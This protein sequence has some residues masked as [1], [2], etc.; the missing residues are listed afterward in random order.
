MVRRVA[1]YPSYSPTSDA[2]LAAGQVA[3]LRGDFF[4]PAVHLASRV[5]GAAPSS[6]VWATD[7]V[8]I[9]AQG[10][11]NFMFVPVGRHSLAGFSEPVALH[12]LERTITG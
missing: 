12:R 11:G 3:A 8:C 5:V 4:G 9:R 6:S 7:E 1:R 10:R 2:G